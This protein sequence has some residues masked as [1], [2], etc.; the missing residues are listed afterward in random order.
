MKVNYLKVFLVVAALAAIIF[1]LR[2]CSGCGKSE[3]ST[4]TTTTTIEEKP[5]QTT[6][7]TP[8][9]TIEI[10]KVDSSIYTQLEKYKALWLAEQKRLNASKKDLAEIDALL[11]DTTL[12]LEKRYILLNS[13][14]QRLEREVSIAE[15]NAKELQK[16]LEE[17]AN[18]SYMVE[19]IDSTDE[20][21]LTY[22]IFSKG[23]LKPDGFQ[24]KVDVKG[25]TTTT[26]TTEE[27]SKSDPKNL[28]VGAMYG[29]Q[30][31]D[32][33]VYSVF[34]GKDWKRFG[35]ISQVGVDKNLKTQVSAG[36]KINF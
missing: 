5:G 8:A 27:P 26:T 7:E 31:D 15:N 20:Y 28:F 1:A 35:L 36:I 33:P 24:R 13:A 32:S 34:F 21:K 19:G 3:D 10:P 18:G 2:S 22:R 11:K 17:A 30:G 14:K 12:T 9:P 6:I 25:K 29:L 4:T 16:K 23:P